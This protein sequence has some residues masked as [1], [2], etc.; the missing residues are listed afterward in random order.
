[1]HVYFRSLTNVPSRIDCVS[2]SLPT[3]C[4]SAQRRWHNRTAAPSAS[5]SCAARRPLGRQQHRRRRTR[6][7]SS[8]APLLP[9]PPAAHLDCVKPCSDSPAT[10]CRAAAA[11]ASAQALSAARP[12][13]ASSAR[14]TKHQRR[15][16][17]ASSPSATAPLRLRTA[18]FP[19]CPP[20]RPAPVRTA[21]CALDL[22]P[23]AP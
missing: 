14:R 13:R 15:C 6:R 19:T 21:L 12:C 3:G 11:Q 20:A 1:M 22:S 17:C 18:S 9:S 16:A 23:F 2:G 7:L 5:P 10:M 8:S 4:R